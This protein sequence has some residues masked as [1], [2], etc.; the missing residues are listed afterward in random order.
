MTRQELQSKLAGKNFIFTDN[1]KINLDDAE[2]HLDPD[3]YN[4]LKR[5]P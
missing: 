5:I 2:T 3:I 4:Y 1:T